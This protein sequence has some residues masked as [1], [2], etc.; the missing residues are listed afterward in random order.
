MKKIV[1][2]TD[3]REALG[4]YIVKYMATPYFSLKFQF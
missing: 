1:V 2:L 3:R 4:L